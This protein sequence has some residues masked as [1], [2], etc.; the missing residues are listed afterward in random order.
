MFVD[1]AP[2]PILSGLEG[3]DNWMSGGLVMFESVFIL[4]TFTAAYMSAGQA[5]PQRDP[6]ISKLKTC[7]T[8][9]GSRLDDLDPSNVLAGDC[10]CRIAGCVTGKFL[11]IRGISIRT[12][13]SVSSL[14]R[15]EGD[16]A[17]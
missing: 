12:V 1:V 3:F 4:G 11:W 2:H 17:S 10:V 7:C 6:G 9:F 5:E 8:T 14:W 15:F 13:H 16:Q